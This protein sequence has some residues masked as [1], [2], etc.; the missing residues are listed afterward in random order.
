M[1]IMAAVVGVRIVGLRS[2]M[3]YCEF[4]AFECHRAL[5]VMLYE[6]RAEMLERRQACEVSRI[7]NMAGKCSFSEPYSISLWSTDPWDRCQ[8]LCL[9]LTS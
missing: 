7:H 5:I 9:Q 3:L 8:N 6:L 4:V 1:G 2:L